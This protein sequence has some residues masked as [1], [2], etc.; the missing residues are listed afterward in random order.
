MSLQISEK[1]RELGRQAQEEVKDP[2]AR[3]DAIAEEN[4][5]RVLD[6]FQ[7]H[8]VA[9]AYFAGT[10]GYGYDD[11]GRDKLDEIYAQIF[12]TEAALVRIQFV[13]GTHAIAAAVREA[14]Q[15][16]E[17]GREK[18]ILFNLSGNGVIDLYAY[19]QYLSG[20]LKD[21]TPTD[22]EIRRSLDRIA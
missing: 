20:A 12:G 18:T 1:V 11:L 7:T 6:A 17:E 4:A 14:L 9:D 13:N 21:Y 8:R 16:R 2:F 22:A 15:A 5:A 19:E 3:I 10:T